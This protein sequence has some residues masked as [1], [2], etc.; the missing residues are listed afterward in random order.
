MEDITIDNQKKDDLPRLMEISRDQQMT[1]SEAGIEDH[2]LQEILD[3]ENLDLEKFM[4]QG[5][6]I[7]VDSL[8]KEDYDRVQQ[9]FLWRSQVKG[10]GVKR[11]HESQE[12]SGVKMMENPRAQSPK[13]SCRKIGRKRQNELMNECGKLLIN[14][15]KIKDLTS[16]SFTNLS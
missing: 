7:G 5:K 3:R 13:N 1:P 9:L 15:G 10:A 4:E 14:S 11:N 2:E 12:P 6:N 16:Y 8:P